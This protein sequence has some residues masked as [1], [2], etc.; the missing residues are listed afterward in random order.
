MERMMEIKPTGQ[1]KKIREDSVL[2]KRTF[3]KRKIEPLVSNNFVS[4]ISGKSPPKD[5]VTLRL[6]LTL[7]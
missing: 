3:N 1:L 4:K 2:Q 5:I 7:S 6:I